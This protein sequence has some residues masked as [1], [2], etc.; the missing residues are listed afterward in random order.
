MCISYMY[1][2][3]DGDLGSEELCWGRCRPPL[4]TPRK[5]SLHTVL[6]V[7]T[8]TLLLS[9]G[10]LRRQDAVYQTQAREAAAGKVSLMPELWLQGWRW[11][12]G[13]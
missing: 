13:W 5:M 3:E 2:K 8:A 10:T 7:G 11:G 1:E 4:C 6:E 12:V 9:A